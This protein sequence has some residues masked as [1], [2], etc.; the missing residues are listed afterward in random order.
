VAVT[1]ALVIVIVWWSAPFR[2][3]PGNSRHILVQEMEEAERLMTEISM[4]VENALP[5]VY[6][7]ICGKSDPGFDEE[8][9]QFVVPSIESEAVSYDSGR[10]GVLLC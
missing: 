1:V 4:L 2:I 8:F 9:M 10:G 5:P 7:D 3:T 6:L